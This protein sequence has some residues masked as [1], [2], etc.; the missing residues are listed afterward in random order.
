MALR[1]II[2]ASSLTSGK[3]VDKFDAYLDGQY[4]VTSRE[5]L[6]DGARE[7]LRRGYDTNTLM[8][9]RHDGKAFDSFEPAP[10]GTLVTLRVEESDKRGMSIRKWE[11]HPNAGS[12]PRQSPPARVAAE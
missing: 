9:T 2:R 11:P 7:L 1:L 3:H 4:I 6:F 10:I 5:P 8:T 12:S